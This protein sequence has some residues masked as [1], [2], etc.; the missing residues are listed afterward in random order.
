MSIDTGLAREPQMNA[1]KTDQQQN[2]LIRNPGKKQFNILVLTVGKGDP[3]PA[4]AWQSKSL[5]QK[6]NPSL[7]RLIC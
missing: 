7:L 6:F 1:D 4:Q 3:V 2:D 5:S